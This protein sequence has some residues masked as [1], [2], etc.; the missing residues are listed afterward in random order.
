MNR[1]YGFDLGDA[2]SAVARARCERGPVP[3]ILTICDAKS[4]ITAYAVT[5]EGNLVIGEAAC[6]CDSAKKRRLRFKSRFLTETSAHADI[7]AYAAGVLGE[8]RGSG[9]LVSGEDVLFY[10]GCPAGW[11]KHA[12][13]AYRE[14]FEGVGY[15]PARII[16]ESR[17]ALVSACQSK[18]L[19]I[20]QDILSKP[21]LVVDIGS[22]TTDFAYVLQG[23]E[24]EMRTAGEVTLGGGILDELLL[25]HAVSHSN[26]AEKI[27]EVFVKSEPWKNYCEFA[28]RRLKERYFGDEE[29]YKDHSCSE[30][31]LI[32][33]DKPL[34][35]KIS[36]DQEIAR[37][38]LSASSER[39]HG[40]S[41]VQ[42]LTES[43]E[44]V[45]DALKDDEA[46]ELLFLT[47]GVSRMPAVRA[48]CRKVFPDAVV[49]A[50]AEP[51]FSVARGLALCG[52]ID[53]EL[54]AFRKDIEELKGSSVIEDIVKAHI[55][56]L[57]RSAV[58]TMVPP[59][60]EHAAA[61]VFDMWRDGAIERLD[62]TDEALSREITRYLESDEARERLHC[63]ISAW[64]VPVADELSEY[65]V[66]ICVLHGV[67]YTALSLSAYLSVEDVDIGLE[68]KNVFAVEEITL[69]IDSIISIIV[70]LIC[71]GSGIA[72]ISSGPEGIVAGAAVS[73]LVLILGKKRMEKAFMNADIPKPMRRII[74]KNAFRSRID[75]VSARVEETFYSNLETDKNEEIIGQMV[76]AIALEIETCLTR[77]AEVVEIPLG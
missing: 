73:L 29:Y 52:Q 38:V 28:A 59:I 14:I 4:L 60:L 25:A 74:P 18:H 21:L 47:G 30:S 33:Y 68:A 32:Q 51:E 41:F 17:A 57:Y 43:L 42:V 64:M 23:H 2:E 77:M 62:D 3:E 70:G 69:M 53:A 24:A 58:E 48:I 9:E 63:V 7:R 20:G 35:L 45:R 71:G 75:S 61:P 76:D 19:Q 22:S 65:T 54:A 5:E 39:L 67:P 1:F 72:M 12:R 34:P 66:P 50:G 6:Y 11:D 36:M 31:V 27:R 49:I 55:A 10:I 15:P 56:E 8:L 26:R 16:S 46:P 13:E 40:K 44:E 37:E